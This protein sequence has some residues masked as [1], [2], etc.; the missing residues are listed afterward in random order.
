ML[1]KH[2][3]SGIE[4]VYAYKNQTKAIKCI[5][6]RSYPPS[7]F[8]WRYQLLNCTDASTTCPKAKPNK[9]DKLR[10]FG[11]IDRPSSNT[12]VL[13]V[14]AHVGNMYFKCSVVNPVTR[15]KDFKQ[16]QFI[17][18]ASK[19]TVLNLAL[20]PYTLKHYNHLVQYHTE[21]SVAQ[22]PSFIM[23]DIE[24]PRRKAADFGASKGFEPLA[25]AFVLQ[26]STS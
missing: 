19:Y 1:V 18:I 7:N 22:Q 8:S 20:L 15:A 10:R 6:A 16:Y 3:T 12:S 25:S 17:R 5:T 11:S 14:P 23:Y 13:T 9:W 26:G 2:T 24:V 21:K 4:K